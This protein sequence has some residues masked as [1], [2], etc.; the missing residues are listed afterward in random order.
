MPEAVGMSDQP[1]IAFAWEAPDAGPS[2]PA[3]RRLRGTGPGLF[4]CAPPRARPV[5]N[6]GR[7]KGRQI[8]GF[9]QEETTCLLRCCAVC[10]DFFRDP[11]TI[12]S[13]GHHFCR[14]CLSLCAAGGP[15]C[16]QCRVPFPHGGD[17]SGFSF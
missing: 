15:A 14:R 16:L 3:R 1:R 12:L 6:H 9:L 17:A 2:V 8:S 4:P 5:N 10:L 13:C 7:G 11:V